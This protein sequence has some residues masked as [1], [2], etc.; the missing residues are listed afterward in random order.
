[1]KYYFTTKG[2]K[3]FRG[4]HKTTL[5]NTQTQDLNNIYNAVPAL[6]D[7]NYNCRLCLSNNEDLE[8]LRILVKDRREWTR[9][10]DRIV[11][12][13]EDSVARQ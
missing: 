9:L 10:V 12:G 1:M 11:E 7:N 2:E 8:L 5:P 13:G 6:R 3:G 4:R